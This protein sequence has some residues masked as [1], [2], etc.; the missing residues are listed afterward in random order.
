MSP[1]CFLVWAWVD[2]NLVLGLHLNSLAR[3]LLEWPLYFQGGA[4]GDNMEI[5]P[6]WAQ[7]P[8]TTSVPPVLSESPPSRF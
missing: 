7:A 8:N 6:R 4:D 3:E 2:F 5:L 1:L